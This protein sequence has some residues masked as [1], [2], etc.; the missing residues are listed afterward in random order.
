MYCGGLTSINL[1]GWDTSS[2]TT[3]KNMF[4]GCTNLTSLDVSNFDTSMVINM[5][6]M[7]QNCRS[8]TSLDVSNFDT[9]KVANTDSMFHSCSGLTSLDLSNFDTSR[10]TNMNNM[11]Y[12]CS[13]LTSLDLSNFDTSMVVNMNGMFNACSGLTSLD[14]SNFVTS[15]VTTMSGM[16]QSC[17]NLT[18][19]DLSGWDTSSVTS[20]S[21]MF[22]G[23][24]ISHAPITTFGN[25]VNYSGLYGYCPNLKSLPTLTINGPCN[26]YRFFV[27]SAN[28]PSSIS[29]D[30][31][32]DE[33]VNVSGMFCDTPRG[34]YESLYGFNLTSCGE[35]IFTGFFFGGIGGADAQNFKNFTCTGTLSY[36][37]DLS[38]YPNLTKESLNQIRNCLCEDGTGLTL[39]LGANNLSKFSANELSSI[40]N[41]G[42]TLA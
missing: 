24:G 13:G 16:F 1:S 8:L 19:L 29:F 10:V 12:A 36:S 9:S 35:S 5:N 6:G 39:T 2:A 14:P 26:L 7:F 41:K 27:G 37:K 4:I 28:L 30:W 40:T 42:W 32:T 18:S 34:K 25:G 21:G 23:T 38:L 15:S 17:S 11:F 22:S 20:M 31:Q 33:T 3:M